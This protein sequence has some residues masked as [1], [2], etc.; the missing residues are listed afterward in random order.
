MSGGWI[1]LSGRVAVVTG[2]ASGI[3]RAA[4]AG[5]AAVGARVILLDRDAAGAEAAAAALG[6]TP[7]A[8]DVTSDDDWQAAGDWIAE[9]FG[10]LDVLVNCAGVALQDSIG[11]ASLETYRRTFDINVAG[12]L[13][14]MALA[15]RFMR[16]QAAGAIVNVS[17]AASLRG[18]KLMASYGASKAA[19]AHYTRSAALDAVQ[20]GHDIRVNA[21]HPGVIETPL[22]EDLF[23]IYRHVGPPEVARKVFTTGRTGR[24]DEVADLIVFLASDRASYISGASIVIDRAANA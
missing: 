16:P 6:G 5:L 22:A 7:R 24:P 17:S 15:M 23:R 21:I 14:G 12:T 13:R 4:A 20:S 10:R 2:A 9:R 11:D 1:D 19:V 3:G 8:L 18:S